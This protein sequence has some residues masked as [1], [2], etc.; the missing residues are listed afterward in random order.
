MTSSVTLTQCDE[1]LCKA[2]VK[3]VKDG[4]VPL[5]TVVMPWSIDCR[6]CGRSRVDCPSRSSAAVTPLDAVVSAV[7]AISSR[8]RSDEFPILVM[9][10]A[11]QKLWRELSLLARRFPVQCAGALDS[12]EL[13]LP[14]DDIAS[15]QMYD[16]LYNFGVAGLLTRSLS[17]QRLIAW[18]PESTRHHTK[19]RKLLSYARWLSNPE[20]YW[21]VVHCVLIEVKR[22]LRHKL[23]LELVHFIAAHANVLLGVTSGDFYSRRR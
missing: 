19:R 2:I 12:I 20:S 14:F 21:G 10:M 13:E 15:S 18:R 23:P 11:S 17:I 1:S 9:R 6:S 5:C 4:S 3:R 22:C 7:S 8:R 16:T